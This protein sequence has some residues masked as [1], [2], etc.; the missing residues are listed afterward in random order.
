MKICRCLKPHICIVNEHV[1]YKDSVAKRMFFV[2]EGVCEVADNE[3][4][5]LIRFL[6]KGAFFGEIGC[7]LTEKRTCSVIVRT[8]TI[9]HAIRK[10]KLSTILEE[11]P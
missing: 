5:K 8:T 2:N 9:L 6:T 4:K 1:F 3:D 11:F 10:E 7:F